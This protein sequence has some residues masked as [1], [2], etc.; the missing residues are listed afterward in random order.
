MS[1]LFRL[2]LVGWP[3]THSLSPRLHQAAL[4]ACNL[5]GEY[6]LVPV[7]PLPDGQADLEAQLNHLRQGRLDGL[8]VTIPHKLS[9]LPLLD[10]LTPA[11]QAT[12]AVNT[13]YLD[14]DQLAGDNTDADGFWN[15][16][17]DQASRLHL[18]G[19]FTP[20]T[21]LVLGAGG[22][23]RA[24]VHTLAQHNWQVLISSR[25]PEQ[26]QKLVQDLAPSLPA[27]TLLAMPA[28]E[29][30]ASWLPLRCDLLVN[31]TP[32]GMHP[33]TQASPWLEQLPLPE[34]CWVYD[35]VYHPPETLLMRRAR[36]QGLY[37]T[38]GLGMLVHQAALAFLRWT[39]LTAEKLPLILSAMRAAIERQS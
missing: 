37:A 39:G 30:A 25:H 11:A 20:G 22:A 10:R 21:A 5:D 3:L 8:N 29:T 27:P 24:V 1:Q 13:L 6:V 31:A 2:G 36:Q 14:P 19:K 15:D 23:A 34:A 28:L 38:N 4:Q 12:G 7:P 16:L 35:L 17:Q 32:L 33:H 9:I 18:E 26:A